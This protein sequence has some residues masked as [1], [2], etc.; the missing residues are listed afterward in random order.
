MLAL[1]LVATALSLIGARH[2]ADTSLHHVGTV[3]GVVL[4]VWFD[5]RWRLSRASFALCVLFLA[6]HVLGARYTYSSVPY[7]DWSEALVG[8]RLSEVFGFERNHY[9]RLV[10]LLY[11]LL[12]SMP[13]FELLTA[14][15]NVS[16]RMAALLVVSTVMSTSAVYELFEWGIAVVLA[17]ESAERYNGQQGDYWDAQKDMALAM[18]G[19][20]VALAAVMLRPP[21]PAGE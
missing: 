12:L 2:P 20:C 17:P 7:D 21:P 11:G 1:L 9:D 6:A 4:L 8:R 3:A 14:H 10:H 19:S 5:R 16:G 18:L 15:R 13:L